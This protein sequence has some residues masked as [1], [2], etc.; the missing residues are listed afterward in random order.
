[1][2]LPAPVSWTDGEEPTNIPHAD[3]L[4]L[5]W[6]DSFNFLLGVTRPI[7]L[8][9]ATTGQSLSTTFVNINLPTELL[10]R[11][12]THSTSTNT[13]LITVPYTGQYQGYAAGSF[14]TIS[15]TNL[16]CIIRILQ[17]ASTELARFNNTNPQTGNWTI[18]GTFTA[19]LTAGDTI[20]MQMGMASGTATS[21]SLIS[22]APKLGI[23]Y[24]GDF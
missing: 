9:R 4:N 14:D 11:D 16:R 3:N 18:N 19:N 7:G 22:R 20:N 21:G 5:D 23:W 6:R 12:L 17:N 2:P 10:K 8:F 24:A 15:A 1:M 13:H